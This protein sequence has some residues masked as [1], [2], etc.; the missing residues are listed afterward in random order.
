MSVFSL[1]VS[2][3]SEFKVSNHQQ[4]ICAERRVAVSALP[5]QL[6]ES[7]GGLTQ[8]QFIHVT[9]P[10]ISR[11]LHES[12]G[13]LTKLQD[14]IVYDT[15]ISGVLPSSY[16][17]LIQLRSLDLHNNSLTGTFPSEWS[18]LSLSSL[19]VDHNLF[20]GKLLARCNQWTAHAIQY[21][22]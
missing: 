18:K 17:A 16:T 6:P 2:C 11:T 4:R 9:G 10:N 19:M 8:L 1:V 12:W 15:L 5:L 22:R 21:N 13:G 14:L 3:S 20:T 7:W